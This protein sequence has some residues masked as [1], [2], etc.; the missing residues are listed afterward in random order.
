MPHADGTNNCRD[1]ES[2][3]TMI[4]LGIAPSITARK[5][6]NARKR[7]VAGLVD[8]FRDNGP[9]TGSD[10]IRARWEVN[11]S[12][13]SEQYLSSFEIGNL[14]GVL[15]NAVPTFFWMLL[16][17]YSRPTL[18]EELRAEIA[19]ATQSTTIGNTTTQSI[20]VS[21]L[22]EYCPLL[23]SS[24]KETLRVQTHNSSAR[25]VTKD[26]VI[27]DQYL[28][29]A[30]NLI[31]MPGY[32]VHMMPSIWGSDVESFNPHR[33]L[34]IEKAE[35]KLKDKS[36][37]QHPASFRTFGGGSTLCP[38]RHF[39]AAEICGAIAMMVMRFDIKPL[40]NGGT[41]VI[42]RYKYGKLATAVPPPDRDVKVKIRTRKG[43]ED[44]RW[45]LRFEGSVSKFDVF[46]G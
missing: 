15:I 43:M 45:Q 44:V 35:K 8:Y 14:I 16:H 13:G 30:G 23:L 2:D 9:E 24:Y 46:G 32:P 40:D 6:Y 39:A 7:F 10:L 28:L 21:K 22:K 37:K 12:Y 25:W 29:K 36:Q 34:K 41:W 17:I 42:P 20:I 11:K 33:F 19:H 5:G 1:F 38:G 3:L 4:I 27:A 18:L 26:T 31:Q